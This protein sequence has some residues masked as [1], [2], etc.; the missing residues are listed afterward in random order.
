MWHV[1]KNKHVYKRNVCAPFDYIHSPFS[2]QKHK[3]VDTVIFHWPIAYDLTDV[4]FTRLLNVK[5]VTNINLKIS[6]LYNVA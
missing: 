4:F 2:L 3:W 5:Q 6:L 1:K